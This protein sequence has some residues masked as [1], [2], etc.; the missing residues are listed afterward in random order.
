MIRGILILN[1]LL[2]LSSGCHK[3]ILGHKHNK[4]YREEFLIKS[5]TNLTLYQNIEYGRKNVADVGFSDKLKLIFLDSINAKT[6]QVLNIEKDTLI[7]KCSYDKSSAWIDG[8]NKTKIAGNIKIIKW[9][10]NEIILN[11]NITIIDS[12]WNEVK[13]FKGTRTFKRK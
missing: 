9:S 11:E 6:K 3:N 7:I 12:G 8:S 10:S 1:I 13:K 2:L 4:N 5:G